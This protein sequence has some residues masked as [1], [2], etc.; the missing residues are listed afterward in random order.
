MANEDLFGRE[1]QVGEPFSADDSDLLFVGAESQS[2]LVQSVD[3]SYRQNVT[4]LWEVGTDKQYFVAGHTE[5]NVNLARVVGPKPIAGEFFDQYGNICN[6]QENHITFLVRGDC[7]QADG[8]IKVTGVVITQ[9]SYRL[10]AQDMV[11]NET[12]QM[13]AAKVEK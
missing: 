5:G 10:A 1:V 8:M 6:I 9:V 7:A 13:L 3:I 4:R 2:L 11:V 12:V